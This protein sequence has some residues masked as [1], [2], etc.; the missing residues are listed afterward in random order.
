MKLSR[1]TSPCVACG[2]PILI[3]T[4]IA[5]LLGENGRIRWVHPACAP[6][7]PQPCPHWVRRG[8]CHLGERCAL[9]HPPL[10]N[11][12]GAFAQAAFTKAG[13]VGVFRRFIVKEFGPAAVVDVAGGKGELSFELENLHDIAC[14]VVDPRAPMLDD[15]SQRFRRFRARGFL[16]N[17]DE[18]VSEGFRRRWRAHKEGGAELALRRPRHLRLFFNSELLAWT[19]GDNDDDDDDDDDDAF[20][21]EAARRWTQEVLIGESSRKQNY[22]KV[23]GQLEL[24][25]PPPDLATAPD[26]VADGVADGALSWSAKSARA[27]LVSAD[28]LV[29]LHCDG[30]AEPIVDFALAHGK[31][32]AIV[33]C[34]TCS[35]Q[36]PRRR[37][38]GAPVKSYDDLV[39]YLL[40]KDQ[41]I[42]KAHLDFEGRNACLF[43]R[44]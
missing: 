10:V 20:F 24:L 22:V 17:E 9:A 36:F 40:A 23:D 2:A 44:P 34:C 12:P 39:A 7:T 30:A 29:G 37:I 35:K 1:R 4:P 43:F 14:V 42:R 3:D 27:A 15:M 25:P 11:V 28:L 31:A 33:P 6:V 32:F 18:A 5:P 16:D 13:R 41:R 8:V 19:T 21:A 38:N 26:G